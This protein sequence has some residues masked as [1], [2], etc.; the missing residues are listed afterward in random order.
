M[1][2]IE[3]DGGYMPTSANRA[4]GTA[5]AE[6]DADGSGRRFGAAPRAWRGWLVC[7][8]G[9]PGAGS[10]LLATGL[11]DELAA[12]AS[13]R[14]LVRLAD[15]SADAEGA[16]LHG[17]SRST[18]A[19]VDSLT[20]AYRFVVVDAGTVAELTGRA[21]LDGTGG[22]ALAREATRRCDLIAVVGTGD[23]S[24]L[25]RMERSIDA[26]AGLFGADRILPVINRLPRS[27]RR[28]SAVARAA[29]RRLGQ[30]AAFDAGD[31]VLIAEQ[32]S[33][34]RAVPDRPAPAS[35]LC[36]PL[37]AEV[38]LRLS[39]DGPFAGEDTM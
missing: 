25:D 32:R 27:P 28:R 26:L 2:M 39:T 36:R 37:T 31:P 11:A 18:D 10:S 24:G 33:I 29:V 35:S 4:R 12:D 6:A 8:T 7:V 13:N 38:R 17:S 15:F 3:A 5:G 30:T 21:G 14:G 34:G 22:S 1:A 19:E 16:A 9:A 20:T 23:A